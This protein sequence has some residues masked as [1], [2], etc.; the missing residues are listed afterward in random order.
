[1]LLKFKNMARACGITLTNPWLIAF[2]IFL[3]LLGL[4]YSMPTFAADELEGVM[5]EVKLNFGKDSTA[6]KL[7]CAAEIIVGGYTWHK[8]KNPAAVTGV[9]ILSL[10][11]NY[12]LGKWVG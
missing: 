10:F 8:T 6:V 1:M 9:V 12:A 5:K 2:L 3:V 11:M 7:L 4:V